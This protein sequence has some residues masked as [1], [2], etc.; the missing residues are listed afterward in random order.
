MKNL[1]NCGNANATE[2]V[3]EV[4]TSCI[5][6]SNSKATNK[7]L[8][9]VKGNMYDFIT[10]TWNPIKGKCE[11]ECGYCYV[12]K[13][14]K[15]Q[16]PVRLEE[17]ALV[18]DLGSNNFIF[19]GSGT[20]MFATGVKSEWITTVLDYCN[21]FD[22]KYLFQSKNPERFIE[23]INHPAFKK[24]VICTTIESNRDYA[25]C[26]APSIQDRVSA[27]EMIKSKID[28]DIYVTIEPIMAFDSSE[29]VDLIKRCAP[30]QVNIGADSKRTGLAEPSKEEIEELI[31][32]L[33]K[34]TTVIEKKNLKRL[35]NIENPMEKEL[36]QAQK[37][38][39][40]SITMKAQIMGR[41]ENGYTI[42]EENR[43]FGLI[44]ENRPIK[45]SD[46]NGFL[47][48]IANGKYDDT[49]SIVTAEA[50]EL[51]SDYNLVDLKGTPIAKEEAND[52]LIVLDGQHRISAFAKLNAIKD[53]ENQI[54]IPSVHIK[55]DLKNVCEY[56]ADINMVGHNWNTADKVCATA[57]STGN[58][59][60]VKI[61]ELIKEGYNASTAIMICTGKRLSPKELKALLS[62]GDAS[63]LKDEKLSVEEKLN[64]AETFIKTA[65][66][67]EDMT[68]K[69]LT[70]RYFIKGFNSFA[71]STDYETAF[72]A[73]QKLTIEDFKAITEDEDF[74]EKLK[75]AA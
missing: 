62:K 44:K 75:S 46:V 42:K 66:A 59:L 40:T 4:T 12:S 19:V 1:Q 7:E 29:M 38:V 65:M 20:D 52:Y 54:I 48:I 57:I 3:N 31:S 30:A 73:L 26:Q 13:M 5:E 61:N 11:H 14:V 67:I 21:Q 70:K 8:K 71:K 63:C 74:I 39:A 51:I 64:R 37:E 16:K 10:H 35:M 24:S 47:Q 34:F 49:Q 55:K 56:L 15:K 25:D 33:S 43:K 72:S 53:A 18:G 28:I 23:F 2:S 6:Q 45:K 68:I 22:N 36:K 50:T 27:I 32:E 9:E 58:K 60:L 41:T 69:V 17:K